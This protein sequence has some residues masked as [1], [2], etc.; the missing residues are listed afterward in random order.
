MNRQC[1][2][3]RSYVHEGHTWYSQWLCYDCFPPEALEKKKKETEKQKCNSCSKIRKEGDIILGKWVCSKCFPAFGRSKKKNKYAQF[4]K[5]D[6]YQ[7][8]QGIVPLH[9]PRKKR[10]NGGQKQRKPKLKRIEYW[11]V[12]I[13]DISDGKL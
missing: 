9:Q 13:T 4:S 12:V 2:W 5:V 6:Q 7:S 10:K 3:C 11:V 8:T 1:D